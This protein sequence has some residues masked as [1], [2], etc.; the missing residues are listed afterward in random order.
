MLE[1]GSGQWPETGE[2]MRWAAAI[3]S[4]SR[5]VKILVRKPTLLPSS[6][7]TTTTTTTKMEMG[8]HPS[9]RSKS[10]DGSHKRSK[11]KH[12]HGDRELSHSVAPSEL[13]GETSERGR[14]KSREHKHKHKHSADRGRSKSRRRKRESG[15][16]SV[17]AI[18]I[19]ITRNAPLGTLVSYHGP[20]G[21]AFERVFDGAFFSPFLS[22][23]ICANQSD[24]M[25]EGVNDELN[26][27]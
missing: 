26:C 24:S 5:D 9:H 10:R 2:G 19:P 22:I 4:P 20:G 11:S 6:G 1:T 21:K 17:D 23:L 27:V 14:G 12:R 3:S 13:Q 25:K 18:E 7:P 8:Q 16:S 15:D